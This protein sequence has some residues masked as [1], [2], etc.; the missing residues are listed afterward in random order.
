MKRLWDRFCNLNHKN[1]V[2][3]VKF[4]KKESHYFE[5]KDEVYFTTLVF[6]LS[7]NASHEWEK[8]FWNE[9]IDRYGVNN[10]VKIE[11]S[12]LK[13]RNMRVDIESLQCFTDELKEIISKT[14]DEVRKNRPKQ[15]AKR[16]KEVTRNLKI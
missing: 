3:L 16:V 8:A 14:N 2:N 10:I 13:L 6:R 9:F 12:H 11:N 7:T 4:I 1:E 15:N 5:N